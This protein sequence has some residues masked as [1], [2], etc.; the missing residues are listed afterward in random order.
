MT[1]RI[2]KHVV[3]VITAPSGALLVMVDGKLLTGKSF[4]FQADAIRAAKAHIEEVRK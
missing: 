3:Q 2:G 4:I 1:T